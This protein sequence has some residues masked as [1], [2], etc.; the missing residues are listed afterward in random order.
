MSCSNKFLRP[1]KRAVG[2]S[3]VPKKTSPSVVRARGPGNDGIGRAEAKHTHA[4]QGTESVSAIVDH[5]TKM[6]DVCG[7]S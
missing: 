2:C 3:H 4:M 5:A 7:L 6:Y 1:T